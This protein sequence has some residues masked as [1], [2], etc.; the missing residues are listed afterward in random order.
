MLPSLN[1]WATAAR[2]ECLSVTRCA[3][4]V[5]ALEAHPFPA[6]ATPAART[7]ALAVAAEV[8][9]MASVAVLGRMEGSGP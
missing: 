8:A 4:M 6:S 3:A 9:A 7:V 2:C 1:C 5:L